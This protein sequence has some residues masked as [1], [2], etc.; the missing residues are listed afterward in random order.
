[1]PLI[2]VYD[3]ETTS[4][5]LFREPS[6][7]PRQPHIVSLAA[8]LIDDETRVCHAAIDL[9]VRP[10][11]W[12]IPEETVKIHGITTEHALRIGVQEEAALMML[13]TLED[14]A[15]VRVAHNES[16][17][18]RIIRIAIKRFLNDEMADTW[19]AGE[20]YC[21]MHKSTNICGL[22]GTHAG[23]RINGLA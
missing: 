6:S 3:T 8:K 22:S 7:D 10:D 21:T 4:L 11:G 17:D 23:K 19:K 20:K 5:P 9:I 2:L 13:L 14:I 1:M 16:F 15:D 18:A 12:E